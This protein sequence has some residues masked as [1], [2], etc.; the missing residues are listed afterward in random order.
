MPA[1]AIGGLYQLYPQLFPDTFPILCFINIQSPDI[2]KIL[3]L[4]GL[5]IRQNLKSRLFF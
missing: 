2:H 5:H 4:A 3:L 1:E